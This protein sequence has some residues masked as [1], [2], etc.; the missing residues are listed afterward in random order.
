MNPDS[1][2]PT[3]HQIQLIAADTP[4]LLAEIS[5]LAH[6]IWREHYTPIIGARQVDY[7]L[8]RGYSRAALAGLKDTG[9]LFT[10]ARCNAQYVGY[11]GAT[12]DTEN[13]AIIWLDKFYLHQDFRGLGIGRMLMDHMLRQAENLGADTVQLRVN[14]NNSQSISVYKRLGFAVVRED[15]KAIGGGFV[16][17]DY[18]MSRPLASRMNSPVA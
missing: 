3:A 5:A 9:T 18:I 17:D 10:L 14:R 13:A 6:V 11:G 7:M 2:T 4:A 16:M 8:E 15:I 1:T 12:P